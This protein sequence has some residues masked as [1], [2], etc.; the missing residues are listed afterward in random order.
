MKA[1]K[2]SSIQKVS[3]PASIVRHNY[4]PDE[5]AEDGFED[6]D[7]GDKDDQEPV[8]PKKDTS[9]KKK[10]PPPTYGSKGTK[11]KN[12]YSSYEGSPNKAAHHGSKQKPLKNIGSKE[13]LTYSSVD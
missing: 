3:T 12:D 13:Q 7:D 1:S 6:D 8:Q 10:A 11:S 9:E 4:D 2:Q 5:Y